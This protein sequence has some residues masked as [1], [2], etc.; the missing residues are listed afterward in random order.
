MA[1][2]LRS[3]FLPPGATDGK[4]Y[5]LVPDKC[6]IL[7]KDRIQRAWN[8]VKTKIQRDMKKILFTAI[9]LLLTTSYAGAQD[10]F[11]RDDLVINAG[12][13]LNNTFYSG[14]GYSNSILPLSV[15]A[16]YGV[17]DRLINGDN[18][19]IG[20]GG[21]LGYAGAKWRYLG[22]DHG[23]KYRS[24]IIGARGAFHYQFAPALDTYAGAMLGY[25]IVSAKTWG[26]VTGLAAASG[27]DFDFAL[28]LGARYWFN[29][30]LAGF[31]ELGYGISNINIGLSFRL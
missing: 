18:G 13:G 14:E 22:H 16:E 15:S 20:V 1:P 17:A 3:R 12:I 23:W 9:A 28:F 5:Y 30:G 6:H 2:I 19:S 10:V 25:N 27:S 31:L 11:Q 26:S 21:Y 4:K 24:V 7:R 29:P 8:K